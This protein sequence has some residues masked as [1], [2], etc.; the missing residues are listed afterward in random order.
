MIERDEF[1]IWNITPGFIS[2]S[3]SQKIFNVVGRLKSPEKISRMLYSLNG[4]LEKLVFFNN[5]KDINGR[6][7]NFGD[8]NID[9]IN[10]N[11]LKPNNV[12]S[13]RIIL[14]NS[15]EKNYNIMFSGSSI[16][17]KLPHFQLKFDGI[18]YPQQVG[19]VVD[20]KWLVSKDESG[21]PCLEIKK[22]NAGYDR[23]ILFGN[24]DWSSGYEI[25]ARLCVVAWTRKI[26]N[27][28]LLFKWNPHAQGDGT[29]L[30][31]QWSTGLAYYYSMSPGLRIRFGVNVHF[32]HHGK[33][34]GD[35]VLKEKP[36]SIWRRRIGKIIN[37]LPNCSPFKKQ[38]FSQIKLGTKY[39]FHMKVL[40]EKYV[41][42]VWEEGKRKPDP[43]LVVQKPIDR[44]PNGAPGI[45]AYNCAVRIYEFNVFPSK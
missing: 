32:D 26:H 27:I 22:D 39:F 21:E 29:Y 44:L 2:L 23:I 18:K 19:Q 43:Q 17:N 40:P 20:G 9:T 42:T 3:G 28:G 30:P 10:E 37:P 34:F 12:L 36:L 1:E 25:T 16:N 11:D 8:F 15:S 14:K 7:E 5:S 35:Y 33:K 38:P 41:L 13:L 4:N 24:H 45:I 31:T 6:L